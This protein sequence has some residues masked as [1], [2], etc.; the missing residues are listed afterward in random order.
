MRI[1]FISDSLGAPRPAV[2]WEFTYPG[3]LQSK[4]NNNKDITLC[5]ETKRGSTTTRLCDSELLASYLPDIVIVQL[6][7]VDCVP[8][9]FTQLENS[10]LIRTPQ[11]L[12]NKLIWLGKHLRKRSEKRAYVKPKAY[13]KNWQIFLNKTAE[14]NCA[15][16]I[17]PVARPGT[18]FFASNPEAEKAILLYNKC[19]RNLTK[20]IPQAEVLADWDKK[21]TSYDEFFLPEDGYHL[22]KHGHKHMA[23]IL[24]SFILKKTYKKS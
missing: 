8:R 24:Y 15:V 23:E 13:Q 7:L 11:W 10:I 21:E 2:P 22:S 5:Y 19:I 12:R 9:L 17:I 20:T 6:G 3:L 16:I 4:F 14:L 18:I 1:L